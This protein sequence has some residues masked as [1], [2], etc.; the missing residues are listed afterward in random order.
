M[1]KKTK[2]VLVGA[3]L[4]LVGVSSAFAVAVVDYTSAVSTATTEITAAVTTALPLFGT[5]L[6]IG[7]GIRIM[8]KFAK[9]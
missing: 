5:V 6:A 1:F 9:G 2:Q 4:A 7:I 8:H 3:G